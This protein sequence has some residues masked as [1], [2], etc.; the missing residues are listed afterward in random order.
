MRLFFGDYINGWTLY[1]LWFNR[2]IFIGFSIARVNGKFEVNNE[3]NT[4]M[5][6]VSG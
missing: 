3:P 6:K 1:G 5:S 2:K 4:N